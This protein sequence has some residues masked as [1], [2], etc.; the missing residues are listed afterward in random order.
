[1]ETNGNQGS[2]SAGYG[3]SKPLL[4]LSWSP[5]VGQ[6]NSQDGPVISINVMS[7]VIFSK[8]GPSTAWLVL[9]DAV[10]NESCGKL[11]DSYPGY[12]YQ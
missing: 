12:L 4:M 2:C 11:N 10:L 3:A 7:F 8:L 1:M 6:K 5:P 9:K